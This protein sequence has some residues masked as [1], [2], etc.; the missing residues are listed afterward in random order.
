MLGQAIRYFFLLRGVRMPPRRSILRQ[1]PRSKP[2]GFGSITEDLLRMSEWDDHRV[3]EI[4][5]LDARMGLD[6]V[7]PPPDRDDPPSWTETAPF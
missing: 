6:H 3:A 4:A 1:W 7:P 5:H 2:L